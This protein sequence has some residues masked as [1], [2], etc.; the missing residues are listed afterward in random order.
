MLYIFLK[1]R[2]FKHSFACL[3]DKY[4]YLCYYVTNIIIQNW[5]YKELWLDFFNQTFYR[6]HF[7][8]IFSGIFIFRYLSIY[9]LWNMCLHTWISVT[10]GLFLYS[11][12]HIAHAFIFSML[13][14][15]SNFKNA[16]ST[17]MVETFLT[18]ISLF[19]LVVLICILYNLS[20]LKCK[21]P[22]RKRL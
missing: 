1:Y 8:F 16:C 4:S 9:S 13:L 21:E 15:L 17:K 6:G 18:F 22:R 14:T 20:W 5:N 19:F 7:C 10:S 12:K 3:F 2:E 11:S